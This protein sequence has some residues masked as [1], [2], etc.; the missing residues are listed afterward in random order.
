M[1][2]Q[3]PSQSQAVSASLFSD[4]GD[5]LIRSTRPQLRL[6]RHEPAPLQNTDPPAAQPAGTAPPPPCEKEE[7]LQTIR[8]AVGGRG[9]GLEALRQ[10]SQSIPRRRQ[11]T[12][13][14]LDSHSAPGQASSSHSAPGQ[15]FHSQNAPG[16]A[17]QLDMERVAQLADGVQRLLHNDRGRVLTEE[18]LQRL[19]ILHNQQ[20]A[21]QNQ[22]LDS[23]L[24]MVI[25]PAPQSL[26]FAH[27]VSRPKATP[28]VPIAVET[29]PVTME[30]WPVTVATPSCSDQPTEMN[31]LSKANQMAEEAALR[32][33]Q[34]LREMVD[35]KREMK[36]LLTQQEESEKTFRTGPTPSPSKENKSNK[37]VQNRTR[38]H[39]ISPQSNQTLQNT[40]QHTKK[41]TKTL[42]IQQNPVQ[43]TKNLQNPLESQNRALFQQNEHQNYIEYLQNTIKSHQKHLETQQNQLQIQL[44]LENA[45]QSKQNFIKNQLNP[46]ETQQSQQTKTFFHQ[47]ETEIHPNQMGEHQNGDRN[48][49][50]YI[51]YLKNRIKSQQNPSEICQNSTETNKSLTQGEK[52]VFQQNKMETQS[53]WAQGDRQKAQNGV[54][55]DRGAVQS[56]LEGKRSGGRSVL[57]EAGKVLHRVRRQ[58]KLLE[59]NLESQLRTG[60]VLYCHLDALSQNRDWTHEVRIKKTVDSWISSL[61]RDIQ[62]EIEKAS[63]KPVSAGTNRNTVD[64]KSSAPSGQGRPLS[65]LRM[66]G[67]RTTTNNNRP[68]ASKLVVDPDSYLTGVYGRTPHKGLRRTL[69]RSPYLR[70]SS[71]VSPVSPD[72][73]KPRHRIVESVR[74][75]KLKS[76]KTQTS[77]YPDPGPGLGPGLVESQCGQCF[78]AM[79]IPLGRPR[80]DSPHRAP[81]EVT[82][83][84]K[85]LPQQEVMPHS[86]AAPEQEVTSSPKDVRKQDVPLSQKSEIAPVLNTVHVLQVAPEVE[87][88]EEFPGTHFLSVADLSQQ[89]QSSTEFLLEK[90]LLQLEGSPSPAP[91]PYQGPLF[92]PQAPAPNPVQDQA[93]D[94]DFC[95]YSDALENRLV[96]WVEQQ[97]MSRMVSE[98]YHPPPSDPALNQPFDQSEP[99]GASALAGG[100]SRLQLQVGFGLSLDQDLV[101]SL[102]HEVL[103]ET[104]ARFLGSRESQESQ[105]ELKPGPDSGPGLEVTEPK[106][107]EVLVP[108]PEPT[109]VYS[110]TPPPDPQTPPLSPVTTPRT[111]PPPSDLP[112]LKEDLPPEPVAT[113]P[114]SP[115]VTCLSAEP[116]LV[117]EAPEQQEEQ[118]VEA[119]VDSERYPESSP[120]PE[121]RPSSSDPS[122]DHSSSSS[123]ASRTVPKHISEG[124]LLLSLH[125]LQIVHEEG[126]SFNSS[127]QE[128][129]E[130]EFDPPSEGQVRGDSILLSVLMKM[131]QREPRPQ[132]EGSWGRGLEEEEEVSAGEV[133]D[134]TTKTPRTLNASPGQIS[135]SAGEVLDWTNQGELSEG[136]L[137]SDLQM[138]LT[139]DLTQTQAAVSYKQGSVLDLDQDIPSDPLYQDIPRDPQN[140]EQQRNADGEDGGRGGGVKKMDVFVPF[141]K[142][143]EEENAAETDS[144]SDVF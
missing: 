129:Q 130:M 17:P 128:L 80:I 135:P 119:N 63:V 133:R 104:V 6:Q 89:A 91:V 56:G 90:D 29:R 88:E 100:D 65:T 82:S 67:S 2:H 127:L 3:N 50:N 59:E 35:V 126:C 77:S 62:E 87:E 142:T 116:P 39:R 14:L 20:V 107:Q 72:R 13:T 96:Q 81:Q 57:D 97:L 85:A 43:T 9:A 106:P 8:L 71:P 18:T 79:A 118:P 137:T 68:A 125:Q 109:L 99:R 83:L 51:E 73:N 93:P 44:D 53:N 7:E 26:P 12:V 40:S 122:S 21:L 86:S 28:T 49:E 41:L 138:A 19:E 69:K 11:V 101:R 10:R 134:I 144:S 121:P 1:F 31:S 45:T 105:A 78:P 48:H 112:S 120:A 32:A 103:T 34:V 110:P 113:P 30:A 55:S 75:V 54:R 94:P 98:M 5:V 70:L 136:M 60:E 95:L 33:S 58:K 15:A 25:R 141:M 22:L 117:Q 27:L 92:P 64:R 38:P 123:G 131:Q 76:C 111:T 124:E 61:T 16:Q 132:P 66:T 42:Q 102:V 36:A 143:A 114:P 23:T 84:P 140:Q 74:G 139:L 52:S 37:N 24:R 108:T 115:L 47:N 46:T 4:T